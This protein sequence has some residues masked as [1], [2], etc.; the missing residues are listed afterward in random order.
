MEI[1]LTYLIIGIALSCY[2]WNKTYRKDYEKSKASEEG[3]EEGM[4]VN[5]LL[6]MVVF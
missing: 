1:M 3:V 5:H 4:A 2:W 6:F